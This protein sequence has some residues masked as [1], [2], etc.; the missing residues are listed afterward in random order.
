MCSIVEQ[1]LTWLIWMT[2]WIL[3]F[4]PA[5]ILPIFDLPRCFWIF[6]LVPFGWIFNHLY[7]RQLPLVYNLCGILEAPGG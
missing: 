3:L 1:F 7:S 5:V 6:V 2:G 4:I